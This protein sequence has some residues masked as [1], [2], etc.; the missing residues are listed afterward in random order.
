MVK[1]YITFENRGKTVTG[2]FHSVQGAG[3]SQT[4]VYHL[5][6]NEFYAGRLRYTDNWWCF[7]NTSKTD[8]EELAEMFGDVVTADP[9]WTFVNVTAKYYIKNKSP[10]IE[11]KSMSSSFHLQGK[12]VVSIRTTD[13][14]HQLN[15]L[16]FKRNTYITCAQRSN[17]SCNIINAAHLCITVRSR[18]CFIE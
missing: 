11:Y 5:M 17:K 18:K 4:N 2:Y 12:T 10:A 14:I 9:K 6:V 16:E 3:I 8:F 15:L 7:D 1:V 13:A